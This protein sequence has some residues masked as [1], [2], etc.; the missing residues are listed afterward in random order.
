MPRLFFWALVAIVAIAPLPLG[1]NR[2]LAWSLLALEVG[3]LWAIWSAH[4]IWTSQ[5]L[6]VSIKR[7]RAP[8]ILFGL[9]CL[10]V[11]IQVVPNV[12]FGLAHPAWSELNIFF[13]SNQPASI[14]LDPDRTMTGLMRWLTYAAVFWLALQ[15]GR[16]RASAKMGFSAFSVIAAA[17]ALYGVVAL[18]AGGDTILWYEKWTGKGAVTS[19]FVNRNSY[20]TF[21]GLGVVVTLCLIF[22]TW[23]RVERAPTWSREGV[24]DLLSRSVAQSSFAYVSLFL[25]VTALLLTGSRA[26]V[27]STFAAVLVLAWQLT[28]A[29]RLTM[30]SQ[31]VGAGLLCLFGVGVA[32]YSGGYLGDRFAMGG[33][34]Q[35]VEVYQQTLSAIEDHALMGSGLGSF[36]QIFPLYR[37]TE[38]LRHGYTAS[39]HNSYLEN[40]LELG[41]PAAVCLTSALG[42]LA[43]QCGRGV[44]RRSR[45][46]HF[47][48]MGLAATVL[49]GLHA[50]VDFSL[51]IPAVVVAYMY[52]MGIAVAQS[53]SSRRR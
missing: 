20:A 17:Y 52:L 11:L 24:Y 43:W 44:V 13:G 10:W 47:P 28:R 41:I 19:T 53:F 12:P 9:A 29:R 42:L 15:L 21:A 34:P 39:A 36:P 25:S 46:R 8:L 6:P 3:V 33:D 1:S 14:T 16:D 45:D 50:F 48:A 23:N 38:V 7:V 18:F 31:L 27:L 40:A 32:T 22:S 5:T 37:Q 51:Q 30:R 35:R 49:V 4:H 26:G 2:P